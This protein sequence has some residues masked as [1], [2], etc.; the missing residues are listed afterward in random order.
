MTFGTR[1]TFVCLTGA[2]FAW[3]SSTVPPWLR[4]AALALW[5]GPTCQAFLICT[6]AGHAWY[7]LRWAAGQ[8]MRVQSYGE[9]Q[10]RHHRVREDRPGPARAPLSPT[11]PT[12][13][14][15]A[16]SNGGAAVAPA[17]SKAFAGYADMLKQVPDLDAGGDLHAAGDLGGPIASDCLAAGKNV[18]LEKPPAGTVTEVTDIALAAK[19]AGKVAFRDL[20]RPAQCSR[21]AGCGQAGPANRSSPCRSPGRKTSA[22]GIRGRTGSSPPGGFGIFDPGINA[23]SI[24]TRIMPEPV[25]IETAELYF[26]ANRQAP[27][28]ADLTLGTGFHEGE[29]LKAAFD[30]RQTGPQTWEIG[31]ETRRWAE[32]EAQQRRGP[33]SRPMASRPSWAPPDEYPDIYRDFATLLGAVPVQGRGRTLPARRRRL[34]AGIPAPKWTPSSS[35]RRQTWPSHLHPSEGWDREPAVRLSCGCGRLFSVVERPSASQSSSLV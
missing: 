28:A 21:E 15:V 26:P 3:A 7:V 12:S 29:Q 4:S 11:P 35:E 32:V 13:K 6:A 22:A 19:T 16:I 24:L 30:W 2:P 18:L 1:S 8:L 14:L 34:H 23:L 5:D 25:F 33:G 31:I 17:G 20:P 10:D 9:I 27:I